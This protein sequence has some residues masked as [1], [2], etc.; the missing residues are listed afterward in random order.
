[1]AV[2]CQDLNLIDWLQ[3]REQH[4]QQIQQKYPQTQHPQLPAYRFIQGSDFSQTVLSHQALLTQAKSLAALMQKDF[5]QGERVI[6]LYPF[7]L[8]YIV[9]FFAC[10]Y[11]GLI[12]VPAFPPNNRRRDWGR[13]D[14]IFKNAA[15]SLVLTTEALKKDI[16]DWETENLGYWQIPIIATDQLTEDNSTLW[17]RPD[18]RHDSVAFLQYSSGSTGTPK[19]VVV[20]HDNIR[21]NLQV[22]RDGFGLELSDT[23]ASWLP[24][25]HDMGLIGSVLEPFNMSADIFLISPL[26]VLQKPLRWLQIL[27]DFRVTTSGGPNFIYQHCLERISDADKANL[28]LSCWRVAYNGA[29]PINSQTIKKFAA[30]FESCGF[31]ASAFIPCYGMAETTLMVSSCPRN[32]PVKYTE[33]P[34]N[35]NYHSAE[36]V[37]S[38]QVHS[39]LQVKIV[40]PETQVECQGG[41]TGEI[42]I[43]GAS[44]AS[45]YW[46]LPELSR[47]TFKA[48]L[49]DDENNWLRSGDLGFKQEDELFVTGRLKELIIIR[50]QNYYPQDIEAS[51]ATCNEVLEG[52]PGAAFSIE[53]NGIEQLVVVHEVKRS[54]MRK[55]TKEKDLADEVLADI[56]QCIAENHQLQLHALVLIKPATLLR[57]TSG[58]IRRVATRDAYHKEELSSLFSWAKPVTEVA[59]TEPEVQSLLHWLRDYAERRINSR[60]IDE[61]RAIPPYIVL[62]MGNKGLMG[63]HV[64]K[65]DGGSGFS[66]R[67]AMPIYQQLGAM[68]PSLALFVGLGNVLGIRPLQGFGS[69]LMRDKYLTNLAQ[70]RMLAAFAITEPVAGSN[71]LEMNTQAVQDPDG[72]FVLTG[73]KIWSGSAA[74][75][76]VIHV[77]ARTY[78]RQGNA[79]GITAF[80]VEQ[81]LEGLIID[82]EALTLGMRGTCQSRVIL[83]QVKVPPEAMLGQTGQG[84][85]VAQ[86]A[87]KMGRLVITAAAVGGMKRC[88]QLMHR[89][90]QRRTVATG[91]L[92]ENPISLQRFQ[93][94]QHAIIAIECLVDRIAECIDN[95]ISVPVELYA[96]CKITGPEYFWQL[97]DNLVQMLGGRGYTE[98]NI[99]PQLL[100]DARVLRIFEG[101]TETLSMFLGARIHKS[102][103]DYYQFIVSSFDADEYDVGD[104]D[105]GDGDVDPFTTQ[106]RKVMSELADKVNAS[107]AFQRPMDAQRWLHE[108]SGRYIALATLKAA[109]QST[110]NS[111]ATLA[112]LDFQ[113]QKVLS[114]AHQFLA[115]GL[116]SNSAQITEVVS[117]Y[118]DQIGDIEQQA[119][120]EEVRLDPYLRREHY[121][122]KE[123]ADTDHPGSENQ[124]NQRRQKRDLEQPILKEEKSHL[125]DKHR[126]DECFK[127]WISERLQ[128]SVTDIDVAQTFTSFGL[129]S[130][131][132]VELTYHL[133]NEFKIEVKPD[134]AWVY[135]TITLASTYLAEL[136]ERQRASYDPATDS[137]APVAT[138]DAW[139][140][141]EI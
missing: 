66:Y 23:G 64:A 18:C 61:R 137:D 97:A 21:H 68:D 107:K 51:V 130:V 26:D 71:P 113:M 44:V 129:D 103:N 12:A 16:S 1:M 82:E 49:V 96:A 29:E 81:G 83:D 40:N 114:E 72:N 79:L 69:Q 80:A 106:L 13:I 34:D 115:F 39:D 73:E 138:K 6:L 33:L 116:R 43:R 89:Y 17:Q 70:G 9:A 14:A 91:S 8:D 19:G 102:A 20:T 42:W 132:A 62:D 125:P 48:K 119:G 140:E 141:G 85:D 75:A 27:S 90:A 121:L 84:F 135:P 57:T 104:G 127:N 118:V 36:I 41:Q 32:E 117:G 126:I 4:L 60:L 77:F 109:L 98:N 63:L 74:W 50:G 55:L 133:S 67:Q 78:D 139:L 22:I 111:A 76:S 31:D 101:P 120:G 58:K 46:Q 100:R 110:R 88:M 92:L 37:S 128:L 3:E 136:L 25:Y 5:R 28:D 112:W 123:H 134:L 11:A 99:A 47:Q 15:P 122:S 65:K 24:I 108:C 2:F 52:C 105:V 10:L 93:D 95:D 56:R 124:K 30:A 7:G 53:C 54:H 59:I 35:L 94:A 87:M 86:D 131:D 38:G 45:G